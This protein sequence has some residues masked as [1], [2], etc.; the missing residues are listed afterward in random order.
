MSYK[1]D[2]DE[3]KF[4]VIKTIARVKSNENGN[5]QCTI[6]MAFTV[7]FG[8]GG[9]VS[10]KRVKTREWVEGNFNGNWGDNVF[11]ITGNWQTNFA[12]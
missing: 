5:P 9:K 1:V 8:D 4:Q 3:V 7:T 2:I 12:D 6:D 11:L 10:C